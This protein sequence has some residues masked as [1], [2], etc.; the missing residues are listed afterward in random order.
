MSLFLL[1]RQAEEWTVFGVV[2]FVLLVA[3]LIWIVVT[4]IRRL[5]DDE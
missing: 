3:A 5:P 1:V 4:L 2:A